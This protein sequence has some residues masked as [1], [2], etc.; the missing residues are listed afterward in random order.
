VNFILNVKCNQNIIA[1]VRFITIDWRKKVY[2][3]R[4]EKC[5]QHRI[6]FRL[7]TVYDIWL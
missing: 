3:P 6:S 4:A 5:K 1:I 7:S 2:L